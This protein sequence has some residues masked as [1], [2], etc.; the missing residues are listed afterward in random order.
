Y[1]KEKDRILKTIQEGTIICTGEYLVLHQGTLP[2]ETFAGE[3]RIIDIFTP[4]TILT[5]T[6]SQVIF[7]DQLSQIVDAVCWANRDEIWSQAN[8]NQVKQLSGAGQWSIAG[9]EPQ[10]EDCVD[11]TD[12]KAGCS[13]ARDGTST[14]TNAKNDWH[15]DPTPSMGRNNNERTPTPKISH[16]EV[17]NQCFLTDGSDPSRHKTTISFTLTVE[18][19]VTA[20]IYDVQG[21]AI[22]TLIDDEKLLYGKNSFEWDGRDDDGRVVPIGIYIC[23]LQAINTDSKGIDTKK[24]TIV[25][26][27][28]LN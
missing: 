24:I 12:V 6:D 21:R 1:I 15:I 27:K 18:S 9:T 11:S 13:I 23:Y 8:A 26:A 14:D 20:R 16:I 10:P 28:R 2:D 19:K 5:S 4:N 7:Y 25:A 3:D 17:S 22:R